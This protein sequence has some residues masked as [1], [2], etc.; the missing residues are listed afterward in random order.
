MHQYSCTSVE[1]GV[2]RAKAR[3]KCGTTALWRCVHERNAAYNQ[4]PGSI[5]TRKMLQWKKNK[6]SN[7]YR[8]YRARSVW[9][10]WSS[11]EYT[12]AVCACL[13]VLDEV[14][15]VCI[16]IVSCLCGQRSRCLKC[17]VCMRF[18]A[19]FFGWMFSIAFE[20]Q[21]TIDQSISFGGILSVTSFPSRILFHVEI[22]VVLCDSFQL[23]FL[24]KN[25]LLYNGKNP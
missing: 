23:L 22:V 16:R 24:A 3:K 10:L 2:R 9:L 14:L 7:R 13:R 19:L 18:L 21:R 4:Y 25:L 12:F 5:D 6:S 20:L 15:C 17:V 1:R 8:F 11:P